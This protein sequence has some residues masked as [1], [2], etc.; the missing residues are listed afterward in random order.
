MSQGLGVARL[1]TAEEQ[2]AIKLA[3]F[4]LPAAQCGMFVCTNGSPPSQTEVAPYQVKLLYIACTA[5]RARPY[6]D[7]TSN[8]HTTPLGVPQ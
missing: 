7:T 4:G 5:Q 2:T 6:R 1:A 3:D 8:T